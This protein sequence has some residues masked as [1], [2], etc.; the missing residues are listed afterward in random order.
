MDSVF[1]SNKFTAQDCSGKKRLGVNPSQ[2]ECR[3][4]ERHKNS[5]ALLFFGRA[6]KKEGTTG[7]VPVAR[8][9]SLLLAATGNQDSKDTNADQAKNAGLRYGDSV[10][11]LSKGGGGRE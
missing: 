3:G 4:R 11:K 10:I 2:D 5:R 1:V 9:A 8:K 6:W 7:A